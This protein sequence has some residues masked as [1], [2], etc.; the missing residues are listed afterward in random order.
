MGPRPS[1]DH[2]VDRL[3]NDN[4][5]Y[6][7]GLCGWRTKSEQNANKSTSISLTDTERTTRPLIEWAT[8]TGQKP[9]TM[10]K[11]RQAGWTDVEVIRGE[12]GHTGPPNLFPRGLDIW[13]ESTLEGRQEWEHW[14]QTTTMKGLTRNQFLRWAINLQRLAELQRVSQEDDGIVSDESRPILHR[15]KKII[16]V[17]DERERQLIESAHTNEPPWTD[18]YA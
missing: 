17:C 14:Y 18:P 1:K 10:R 5:K 2:T 3:D 11:R 15:Y 4:P 9:D 12:R 7:P 8:I 13:P 16:E 6:G